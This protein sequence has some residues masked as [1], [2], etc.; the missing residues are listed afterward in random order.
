MEYIH[1]IQKRICNGESYPNAIIA[2]CQ[3]CT[4]KWVSRIETFYLLVDNTIIDFFSC[5]ISIS[6]GMAKQYLNRIDKWKEDN[7]G[8]EI[9]R[10]QNFINNFN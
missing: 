5:P 4:N 6:N 7:P 3:G 8:I 10:I 2:R 1:I 9:Q